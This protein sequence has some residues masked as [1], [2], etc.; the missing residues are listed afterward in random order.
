MRREHTPETVGDLLAP[1][2]R[3]TAPRPAGVRSGQQRAIFFRQQLESLDAAFRP[4][5][6]EI[7]HIG[8]QQREESPLRAPGR[9]LL[10]APGLPERRKEPR[11]QLIK[12]A[13]REL[14]MHARESP[15]FAPRRRLR[16]S[17]PAG[18]GFSAAS[19]AGAGADASQASRIA[20]ATL[21]R[22][23]ISS[24]SI[25]SSNPISG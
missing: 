20:T 12:L 10:V 24:S 19:F 6:A 9:S 1:L 21:Y 25:A 15:R 13:F 16:Y 5:H 18:V 22:S 23:G 14:Q 7:N 17:L 4:R 8:P 3:Q 11:R 2:A